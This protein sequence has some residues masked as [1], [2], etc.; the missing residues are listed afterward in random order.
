MRKRF[1]LLLMS[2]LAVLMFG[3]SVL[4]AAATESPE[5]PEK[6]GAAAVEEMFETEN[7][8]NFTVYGSKNNI[9]ITQKD[10][11]PVTLKAPD[12]GKADE[13]H[14]Q[15]TTIR[16]KTPIL[17]SDNSD[18]IPFFQ[19]SVY[20]Q[21]ENKRDFDAM[22]VTLT[23][24]E[25][26]TN[27]ISVLIGFWNQTNTTSWSTVYAKGSGQSYLGYHYSNATSKALAAPIAQGTILE[28]AVEQKIGDTQSLYYDNATKTILVD[29]GWSSYKDRNGTVTND[30][31]AVLTP[32][33]DLT[34]ITTS[35]N[36]GVA[37]T[38]GIET[39]YLEITTIRGFY[40][41][42]GINSS[43]YSSQ[44][45]GGSGEGHT[46]SDKGARYLIRSIDGLNFGLTDDKIQ[47][48]TPVYFVRSFRGNG[49]AE[50]PALSKYTVLGGISE[51]PD[52]KYTEGTYV[53]V[54]DSEGE[55]V[56]LDGTADGKW[57]QGCG[58]KAQNGVFT[59]SY[60]SDAD[61]KQLV[62]SATVTVYVPDYTDAVI[63]EEPDV[64][65]GT[66][67]QFSWGNIQVGNSALYSGMIVTTN[68]SGVV[69][70]TK[71][72]DISDNTKD[73]ILFEFISMPNE[74]GIYDFTS[75][76]FRLIDKKAPNNYLT[77]RLAAGPD[78][79][80]A[81][82]GLRAGGNNQDLYG[83]KL[84]RQQNEY[85]MSVMAQNLAGQGNGNIPYSSI[86]LYYDKEENC[87]YTSQAYSYIAG[88]S[89][90]SKVRDFD[91]TEL[92]TNA[93][94]DKVKQEAWSGFTGDTVTLE[95]TVDS[96]VEGKTAK[97]GVLTVDGERLVKRMTTE[98]LF[99]GVA[100]YPYELPVPVYVS[101]L[102][103][104]GADFTTAQSGVRVLYGDSVI[105]VDAKT[106]T[107]TPENAGE[108]TVQ[109]AVEEDGIVYVSEFILTVFSEEEAP[110]FEFDLS[111]CEV[112]EGDKYYPS[113]RVE[114]AASVSTKLHH[115]GSACDVTVQIYLEEDIVQSFDGAAF[116]YV[117]AEPGAYKLVFTATDKV[118][119][120]DTYEI[121]FIVERT[122]IQAADPNDTQVLYDRS[123]DI[124]FS[125]EDITVADI[126]V[127]EGKT[128]VTQQ[129][130]FASINVGISYSFAGGEFK[131]WTDDTVLEQLGDYKIRYTVS[132][133]L[134]DGGQ[135][136]TSVFERDVKLVDNTPPVFG[137]AAEAEGVKADEEHESSDSALYYRGV[138]GSEISV[139]EAS[140]SDER[141]GEPVDLSD[142][143][144]VKYTNADGTVVEAEF[145]GGKFSF[146]PGKAG[147][148]YVT[149]TVSDGALTATRVYIFDVREAWMTVGF[150]S[151]TLDD[152]VYGTEYTL[153]APVVKDYNGDTI[154]DATV[155]VEIIPEGGGSLLTA[156]DYKF[157]PD[158]T[159]S[160]RVRYTVTYSGETVE[161]TFALTVKDIVAP[162]V[163][164]A[165]E[166]P[167]TATVGD[168]VILPNVTVTDDRDS[169]LEYTV[170]LE[171]NGERRELFDLS[172]K[173]EEAGTYKV[174]VQAKDAAGNPAEI[175]AEITVNEPS[176]E[177][178]GCNSSLAVGIPMVIGYAVCIAVIAV[179]ALKKKRQK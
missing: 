171:Y 83:L 52:V 45:R 138:I 32:V 85:D 36:D 79:A 12:D 80:T 174:I 44:F 69:T 6:T 81:L 107:F 106:N 68:T 17:L 102:T 20:G 35:G 125:K 57:A 173:A 21:D 150:E 76:T 95:I 49:Y 121:S 34:D 120:Q 58:F 86:A 133:S 178:G 103:G 113:S 72:I 15:T 51:E 139:S 112:K 156:K 117:F 144:T 165:Q 137:A 92:I 33:R 55:I 145:T 82:G 31:G 10:S 25:D 40:K 18:E 135:S 29:W 37:Y 91:D 26:E 8:E 167:K 14:N 78:G 134:E 164:F 5:E 90:K 75:V 110:G 46:L 64:L 142:A 19:F 42:D 87:L 1:L 126:C 48:S 54:K 89:T 63:T 13:T 60:Y 38:K 123:D 98:F 62:A 47:D 154:T 70:Y 149:F 27:Q 152:A 131:N 7:T 94:G 66:D 176:S 148:Y 166:V 130:D 136:Y 118:T 109:Y 116:E 157:T 162:V 128:V 104:M 30:A 153:P 159:G 111:G 155:T 105:Q 122:S 43:I 28:H 50:L 108:Y 16:Y 146:T 96:I 160:F 41:Y 147:I 73:D 84:I 39:A 124:R 93:A 141:H 140:A 143:I 74:I 168:T 101:G 119:R 56:A 177:S 175:S 161:K 179:L 67:A 170:W 100:G 65:S 2:L 11:K 22:I 99:D 158:Q 115:D 129:E 114:G 127:Q 59:V 169:V 71:D 132:Y 97:Y 3:S 9:L 24:T 163:R 88:W 23:D 4:A 53:E 77:V 61:K 151:E 172:F